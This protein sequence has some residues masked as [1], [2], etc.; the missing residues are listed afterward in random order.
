MHLNAPNLLAATH[1]HEGGAREN[2][3]AVGYAGRELGGDE[4]RRDLDPGVPKRR[5]VIDP[6]PRAGEYDGAFAGHDAVHARQTRGAPREE[7][8]GHVA[9]LEDRVGLDRTGRDDDPA[10]VHLQQ[11]VGC[12]DRHEAA[13]VDADGHG[14]LE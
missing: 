5:E 7:H 10:R 8:A 3:D 6:L 14:A 4:G 12:G 1:S 2:L 13:L 9:A 11:L